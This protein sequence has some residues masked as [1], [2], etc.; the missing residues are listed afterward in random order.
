MR[1]TSKTLFEDEILARG[2]RK[3]N[4]CEIT[5]ILTK[6]C[7]RTGEYQV[8]RDYNINTGE[9]SEYTGEYYTP[10]NLVEAVFQFAANCDEIEY[11]GI[12]KH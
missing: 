11:M 12:Y 5:I 1:Y 7:G 3:S 10:R 8:I 6:I 9:A 2:I 4:G